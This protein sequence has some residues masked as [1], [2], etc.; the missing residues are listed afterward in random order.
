M[1]SRED[2]MSR[3]FTHREYYGQFV[4]DEIKSRV[5]FL[6]PQVLESKD[7]YLNDIPLTVWDNISADYLSVG[8]KMKEAGDYLTLAGWVCIVKE[9]ARQLSDLEPK[10]ED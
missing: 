8:R 4:D 7:E 9:A 6:L 3:K 10:G 5:R 2:Y 1:I